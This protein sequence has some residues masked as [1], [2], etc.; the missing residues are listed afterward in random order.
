MICGDQGYNEI[1][2]SIR[3]KTK[4]IKPTNTNKNKFGAIVQ[5]LPFTKKYCTVLCDMSHYIL[6]VGCYARHTWYLQ[7]KWVNSPS[8]PLT[9]I[10]L[11]MPLSGMQML[12]PY[13]P[14][15]IHTHVMASVS[16][17]IACAWGWKSHGYPFGKSLLFVR[18]S[19]STNNPELYIS[20]DP[21]RV[22][23]CSTPL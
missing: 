16:A 20:G 3:I 18:T 15:I 12:K 8:S 1:W 4:Y 14:N 9:N 23:I 5:K 10:H 2:I 6:S 19:F 7:G 13:I 11:H 17:P 22:Q 21:G